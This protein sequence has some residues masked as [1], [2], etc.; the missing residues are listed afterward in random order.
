[1]AVW[2]FLMTQYNLKQ[3]LQKFGKRG[4]KAAVLELKQ[5]YII[6]TWAVIDSGELTREDKAKALLLSLLLLKEN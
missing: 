5:L 2:G 6:D 4:K 1:M 3:G